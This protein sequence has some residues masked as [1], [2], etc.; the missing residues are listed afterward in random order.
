MH[1]I[2]FFTHAGG[3]SAV[4]WVKTLYNV[5]KLD[6]DV[7]VPGHG[8]LY[9]RQYVL[10][11]AQKFEILNQRMIDLIKAGVTKEEVADRLKVDD[12]GWADTVSSGPFKNSIPGYYDEMTAVVAAQTA[13]ARAA[14]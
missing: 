12:L 9:S 1:R 7:V 8:P 10:E 6:F 14:Q 4:E 3:A 5:L 2:A 13:R 11:Y